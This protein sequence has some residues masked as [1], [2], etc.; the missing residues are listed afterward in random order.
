MNDCLNVTIND[1]FTV[2]VICRYSTNTIISNIA[3]F[4]IVVTVVIL[5]LRM[6]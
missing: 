3:I 5:F 2:I 4:S 6:S 1:S